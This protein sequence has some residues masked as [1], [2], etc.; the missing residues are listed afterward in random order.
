[1]FVGN[2]WRAG[3]ART[4]RSRDVHRPHAAPRGEQGDLRKFPY[5]I[6][7]RRR[8]L[9]SKEQLENPASY[10][11]PSARETFHDIGKTASELDKLVTI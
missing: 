8:K 9:L 4:G 2:L 10:P 11:P 6:R 5:A 7:T 1:M 3:R